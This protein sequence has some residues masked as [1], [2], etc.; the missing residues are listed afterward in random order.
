MTN[1]NLQVGM[2]KEQVLQSAKN[3]CET[4]QA[5]VIN[6]FNYDED[7]QISHV[8]ELAI[9]NSIFDGTGKIKMPAP[10]THVA[11]MK[12]HT[13][14]ICEYKN[15]DGGK[16]WSILYDETK[17]GYADGHNMGHYITGNELSTGWYGR[18][19]N[20]D[21]IVENKKK[22]QIV[23]DPNVPITDPRNI[24]PDYDD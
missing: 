19:R 3:L 22:Y 4:A 23:N 15:S 5:K 7:G 12:G 1:F 24:L 14:S 6:F 20:L 17:D 2:K 21:G 9:L 18:D 8:N 11:N 10:N 13:V 16:S